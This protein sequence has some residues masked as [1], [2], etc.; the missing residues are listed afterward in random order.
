MS[1]Y[2]LDLRER[3]VKAYEQGQNKSEIARR[4]G[5]SRWTVGRYLKRF[6]AGKLAAGPHPG[7]KPWLN[8]A[9]CE[10]LSR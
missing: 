3:V 5:M 1:G 4:Y 9:H 2:S 6:E 7:P 8:E 10:I